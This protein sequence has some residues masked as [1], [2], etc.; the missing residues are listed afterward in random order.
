M[1]HTSKTAKIIKGDIIHHH[2]AWVSIPLWKIVYRWIQRSVSIKRLQEF[3]KSDDCLRRYC[4]LSGGVFYFEPPCIYRQVNRTEQHADNEQWMLPF[5]VVLHHVRCL[6]MQLWRRWF[7]ACKH[8]VE[9]RWTR[10]HRRLLFRPSTA[11]VDERCVRQF[12]RH[13]DVT[14]PFCSS[15][16]SVNA[17]W[18]QRQIYLRHRHV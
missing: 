3:L 6:C 1:T 13:S 15:S 11:D 9:G 2:I 18:L 7:V 8:H 16:S 12:T 4:I 17:E 5:L 14:Q 10:W